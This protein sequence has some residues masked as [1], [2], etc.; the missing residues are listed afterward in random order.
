ME[1]IFEELKLVNPTIISAPPRFY[2]R[3]YSQF[4][5]AITVARET[6]PDYSTAEL[7][8]LIFPQFRC[9]VLEHYHK[10]VSF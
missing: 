9:A 1:N 4:Q 10:S 5:A 6:N 8:E 7:E 2:D 3:I